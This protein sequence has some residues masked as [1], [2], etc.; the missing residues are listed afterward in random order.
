MDGS[1]DPGN[2]SGGITAEHMST[3]VWTETFPRSRLGCTA[4]ANPVVN[5]GDKP[6]TTAALGFDGGSTTVIVRS[7]P[8]AQDFRFDIALLC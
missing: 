1:I 8:D 2:Q 7:Q 6:W 4:V 3:G 5:P